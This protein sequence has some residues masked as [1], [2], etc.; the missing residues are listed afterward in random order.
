MILNKRKCLGACKGP[1]N[2]TMTNSKGPFKDF[3][4]LSCISKNKVKH[5]QSKKKQEFKPK[6]LISVT[7][8]WTHTLHLN[9]SLVEKTGTNPVSCFFSICLIL[10]LYHCWMGLYW[11]NNISTV[12][13][14]SC[15]S[16]PPSVTGPTNWHHIF[17]KTRICPCVV[18]CTT[19]EAA[20]QTKPWKLHRAA[21][22]RFFWD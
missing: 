10:F 4:A 12:G 7:D 11:L 5:L 14:I 16:S 8:L 22:P 3:R 18:L 6:E 15:F 9:L 21:V 2:F 20:G 17:Q 19:P 1:K 13:C